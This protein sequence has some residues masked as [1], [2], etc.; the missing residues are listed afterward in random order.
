MCV[1]G[2]R[3]DIYVGNYFRMMGVGWGI[4]HVFGKL[5]CVHCCWAGDWTFALE[6]VVQCWDWT[7]DFTFM[8]HVGFVV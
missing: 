6:I 5:V 1:L 3:L 2:K 4:G 8:M 7:D